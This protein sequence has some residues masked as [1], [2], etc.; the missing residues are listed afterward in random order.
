M[1]ELEYITAIQK[2]YS[3]KRDNSKEILVASGIEHPFVV[4]D[5]GEDI[6][7]IY[8]HFEPQ[9]NPSMV[10]VMYL[11]SYFPGKGYG[12][13]MM[14]MLCELADKMGVRLYLEPVPDQGSN[15]TQGE[16]AAFYRRFGFEGSITMQR[17]PIA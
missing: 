10:W 16:L 11:R 3:G 14:N 12:T 5:H 7:C 1:R 9:M 15:R 6:G 2:K 8:L 13:G 4:E 17:S